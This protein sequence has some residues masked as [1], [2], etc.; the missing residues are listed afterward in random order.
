[1]SKRVCGLAVEDKRLPATEASSSVRCQS[2]ECGE[3][4]GAA[5]TDTTARPGAAGGRGG[6]WGEGVIADSAPFFRRRAT[7]SAAAGISAL[8]LSGAATDKETQALAGL[9]WGCRLPVG[10]SSTRL[11]AQRA[12]RPSNTFRPRNLASCRTAWKESPF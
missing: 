12:D 5:A 3:L 4:L 2:K 1:M 11:G 7:P 9:W 10:A 8:L 6:R